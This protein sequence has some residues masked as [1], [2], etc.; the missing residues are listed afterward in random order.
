MDILELLDYAFF[1]NALLGSLLASIACGIVGTY[2]VT[3]RLVFISGGITHASFGGLG[4]GFYFGLN[5]IFS[6]MVFSVFSAF[7]IQWLSR[8]QGVREDSA[9]AVFWSLGMAVGIMLTFLTPGYAPNLSEY[10]FGNILTITRTDIVSLAMLTSVLCLFFAVNYHA[11]VSVS[12]DTQFARTRRVN[13]RFME[14][15]MMLFVAVTIVLSIR[16]VGIVLLM[17]LITVPQMTANLFTVKY[18]RIIG[19]S[20]LISL[21]GCVAGLMLSYYLNVPSGAF[22][23]FVLI[24]MFA[25]GKAIKAITRRKI[26]P[27]VIIFMITGIIGACSNFPQSNSEHLLQQAK[28][29]MDTRPDSAMSLID[30]ILFPK[31]NLSH[32]NYMDYLITRVEARYKNYRPIDEDTLIFQARDYFAKHGKKILETALAYY[33]SGCVYREQQK[34]DIAMQHYKIAEEYAEK[35]SNANLEG[36][37]FYHIGELLQHQGLYDKALDSYLSARA[38]YQGM[39]EKQAQCLSAAGRMLV[40]LDK[41]DSAIALFEEGIELA[42]EMDNP[43]LKSLLFQNLGV[44]YKEEEKYDEAEKYFRLSYVFSGDSLERPRYYLNFAELY[45]QMGKSDSVAA[46]IRKLKQS[47]TQIQDPY[48]KIGMLRNLA[49]SERSVG[50]YDGA[51]DYLYAYADEMEN[52]TEARMRQS[53]YEVQQKYNLEQARNRHQRQTA[54]YKNWIFSLSGLVLACAMGFLLY[55]LSQ[56]KKLI[57]MYETI[58][59]LRKMSDDQ[60]LFNEAQLSDKVRTYQLLEEEN[61]RL[62]EQVAN[63]RGES[64]KERE[65]ELMRQTKEWKESYAWNSREKNNVLRNALLWQLDVV[66]KVADL[67]KIERDGSSA[68]MLKEFKKIVYKGNFENHYQMIVSFFNRFDETIIEKIRA[69]MPHINQQELLVCLLTY[70]GLSVK[71]ISSL[72]PLTRNTIQAYR[73]KIRRYLNITDGEMDTATYLRNMLDR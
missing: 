15:A 36:L 45:A 46:Y 26:V 44:A 42:Q 48:L 21:V 61:E 41:T 20:I 52:I 18:S 1:R 34:Y 66:S 19:L 33:Y 27:F 29:L 58:D 10:L 69:L 38:Q 50:N 31:E 68:A 6:A 13:T 9:I 8:K 25:A 11:I 51:F 30:S 4:I 22:I 5:P 35:I 72:L 54:V 43:S 59:T 70:V 53:V 62:K 73:G 7:G 14:Y 57:R 28:D 64:T 12:F 2:V 60:Q 37:I 49:E 16:L 39:P 32:E 3:R 65:G 56:K 40:L 67:D 47:L 17:S 55:F 63:Y 71:E 24:L 23:I